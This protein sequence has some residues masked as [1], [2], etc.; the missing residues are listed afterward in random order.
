MYSKIKA[1][2]PKEVCVENY[3]PAKILIGTND[4]VSEYLSKIYNVSK[5]SDK[6][7]TSFET[8][9]VTP[10]YKEKD[11]TLEKNYG[12]ISLLPIISKLYESNMDE[13]ILSYIDKQLLPYLFGYRKGYETQHWLLAVIEMRR[14][15]L[16]ENKV[17]G[18]ILTDLSKAFDCLSH[19]LLLAKLEEY[20]FE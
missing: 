10:I 18:T 19:D 16:D 2:D 3:M 15:A 17:A 20:G 9:D 11:R 14:K 12:P 6:Y 1:L 8:T 4:I 7:P 13:Q 5:N